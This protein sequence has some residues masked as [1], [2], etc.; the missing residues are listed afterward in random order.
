MGTRL[1]IDGLTCL[2]AN[3]TDPS[4][5]LSVSPGKLM[6]FVVED[7]SHIVKNQ[8]Y[9]EIEVSRG[10]WGISPLCRFS[11]HHSQGVTN[12]SAWQGLHKA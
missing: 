12:S 3:E 8:V 2:L 9:A 1:T 6:R 7:G 10:P 5:L 11:C 4:Q